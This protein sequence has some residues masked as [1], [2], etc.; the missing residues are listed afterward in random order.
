MIIPKLDN[1]KTLIILSG[2]V[3]V[4]N[5]L[6]FLENSVSQLADFCTTSA[7]RRDLRTRVRLPL[8]SIRL[9]EKRNFFD[10]LYVNRIRVDRQAALN[11]DIFRVGH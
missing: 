1:T 7:F 2:E 3:S 9:R 11:S 10:F 5:C 8:V 6:L 4:L